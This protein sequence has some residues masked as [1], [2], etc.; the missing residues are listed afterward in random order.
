MKLLLSDFE[1]H[2]DLVILKRGLQYYNKGHVSAF[3]EISHN[4][5]EAIVEGTETYTVRLTINEGTVNKS[6]CD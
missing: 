4:E 3:D 1:Q 2:V 6:V 5:Y